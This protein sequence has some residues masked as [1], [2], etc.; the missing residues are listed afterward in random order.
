[1]E[2]YKRSNAT[3]TFRDTDYMAATPTWAVFGDEHRGF[4]PNETRWHRKKKQDISGC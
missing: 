1:M 2:Q 4:D 3:Q